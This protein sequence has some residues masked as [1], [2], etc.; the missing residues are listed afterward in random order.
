MK[1]GTFYTMG[2]HAI[3][4]ELRS[5]GMDKVSIERHCAPQLQSILYAP[6][7]SERLPL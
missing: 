4:E 6:A 2:D 7:A 5:L 3:A 1:E